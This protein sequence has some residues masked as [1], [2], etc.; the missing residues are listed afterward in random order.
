MELEVHWQ[1][2]CRLPNVMSPQ[3]VVRDSMGR[4]EMREEL[5][6]EIFNDCTGF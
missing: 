2:F 4:Y 3:L 1:T 6:V 5:V